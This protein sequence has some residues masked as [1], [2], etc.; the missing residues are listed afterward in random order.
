MN[1]EGC[2]ASEA[3]RVKDPREEDTLTLKGKALSSQNCR[4]FPAT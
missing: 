2:L 1:E 3:G 4:P